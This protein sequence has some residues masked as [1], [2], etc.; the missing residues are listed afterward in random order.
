MK[1]MFIGIT[2]FLVLLS[3]VGCKPEAKELPPST[4]E[5]AIVFYTNTPPKTD[6]QSLPQITTLQSGQNYYLCCIFHQPDFNVTK[7]RMEYDDR[8]ID[9]LIDSSDEWVG[10]YWNNESW[11]LS[12][13]SADV[14]C[15]FYLIDNLGRKSNIKIVNTTVVAN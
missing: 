4:S 1:K 14:E 5:L 12:S 13:G 15:K 2:T 11:T 9:H 3:F 8:Q 6:F 7:L 10:I